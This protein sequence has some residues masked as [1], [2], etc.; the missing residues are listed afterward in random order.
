MK[1]ISMTR[2]S[3]GRPLRRPLDL[4]RGLAL[5]ITV[6]TAPAVADQSEIMPVMIPQVIAG[7][8]LVELIDG[9][10][11]AAIIN[12]MHRGN[13]ATRSNFI[14]RYQCQAGSATYYVSLYDDPRLAEADMKEMAEIMAKEDHG[15]SHLMRRT[16]N[17]QSVYMALGQGQA[18]YFFARNHELVWLAADVG[19]AEQAL[20]DVLSETE[21]DHQ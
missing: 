5:L 20:E 1:C 3:L 10:R 15:F 8:E 6:M 4:L 18:H 19:I 16:I 21:S 17:G 7:M 11:A 13:V 12:K 9:D 2:L 14:V